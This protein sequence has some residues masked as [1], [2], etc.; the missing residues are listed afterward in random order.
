MGNKFTSYENV[1]KRLE[2]LEK[3]CAELKRENAELRSRNNFGHSRCLLTDITN[4]DKARAI[5]A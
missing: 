3:T 2:E 5:L 4:T 1:C